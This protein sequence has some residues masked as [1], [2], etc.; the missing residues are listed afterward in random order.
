MLFN[1]LIKTAAPAMVALASL[2]AGHTHAHTPYV[3]PTS[4]EPV[5]GGMASFDAS[6]AEAFFVPEAAF[7]NSVF[8]ITTPDGKTNQPQTVVNLKTRVVVEHKLEQDGTYRL[9]TGARKGGVFMIYELDGKEQRAMNPTK[10]LPKRR[11]T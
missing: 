10:P 6:F 9:T 8:Q 1:R 2:T 11:K 5:M 7:N 4:F 3:A